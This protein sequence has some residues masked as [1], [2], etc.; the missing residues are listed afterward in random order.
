MIHFKYSDGLNV[1]FVC[2]MY[3]IAMPMLFP[4]AA[5]TLKL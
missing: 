5:V 4:I 2:L 3:G 1:V